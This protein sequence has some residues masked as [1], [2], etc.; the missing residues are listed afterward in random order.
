M[1]SGIFLFIWSWITWI[2][3]IFGK[4][5]FMFPIDGMVTLIVILLTF[6]LKSCQCN[7]NNLIM[8]N[9]NN[10]DSDNGGDSDLDQRVE[11]Y[12][13]DVRAEYYR[14]PPL[15]QQNEINSNA[16]GQPQELEMISNNDNNNT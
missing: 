14:V 1:Y 10:S 2:F 12:L 15:Y 6:D 5:R 9:N 16:E 3:V 7:N 11:Q 13:K 8:V 4:L